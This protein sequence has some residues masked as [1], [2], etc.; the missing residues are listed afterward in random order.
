MEDSINLND[1]ENAI[2]FEKV[3]R[4]YDPD[5]VDSYIA[6]LTDKLNSYQQ[7]AGTA[8]DEVSKEASR[9][10][11]AT[12][13]YNDLYN[14]YQQALNDV[15]NTSD[16][17]QNVQAQKEQI[18]SQYRDYVA[19]AQQKLN[20]Q[21]KSHLEK[22]QQLDRSLKQARDKIAELQAAN[23][24]DD[25]AV[26]LQQ[27][28]TVNESLKQENS[29]LH[30]NIASLSEQVSTAKAELTNVKEQ[31]ES[32]QNATVQKLQAENRTQ[33]ATI[34]QLRDDLTKAQAA[35]N[36]TTDERIA[37][38][39]KS[40]ADYKQEITNYSETN[41]ALKAAHSTQI[42]KLNAE[43]NKAKQDTESKQKDLDHL[44][45]QAKE[46]L[47]NAEQT[48]KEFGDLRAELHKSES[49]KWDLQKKIA[50]L[51]GENKALKED[52]KSVYRSKLA[53]LEQSNN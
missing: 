44:N 34:A 9:A 51:T 35:A 42:E 31:T 47:K 19:A 49:E 10:D 14:K 25:K 17:L 38:L 2:E 36:Q 16:A 6:D 15:Q 50:A 21:A 41:A 22:E 27:L 23:Q 1:N 45:D 24:T 26:E 48:A 18:D 7:Q 46:A 30:D 12:T 32:A 11:N 3:F 20:D 28:R 43:L 37:A 5:A 39:Q 53:E 29:Q 13:R 40:I 4:G 8:K 33:N 52:L